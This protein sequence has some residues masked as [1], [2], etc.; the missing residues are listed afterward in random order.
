[1]KCRANG[2]LLAPGQTLF[3]KD[4]IGFSSKADIYTVIN[5]EKGTKMVAK[6]YSKNI[7]QISDKK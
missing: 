4:L 7:E 2:L 6:I 5:K 3:I 1:M